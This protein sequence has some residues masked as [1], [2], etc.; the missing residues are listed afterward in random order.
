M[1]PLEI[2]GGVECTVNRVHDAF[3]DQLIANGHHDRIEDL[4]RFAALGLKRL[5]YPVLWERTAPESPDRLQFDWSDARMERM[6]AL[7]VDPI[8]GLLHH[9]SGPRYTSLMDR[10]FPQLFAQYA[11]AVAERYP[12]ANAYTPINEPLTTARF[13]GLY[14]HWFPHRRDD[15]SFARALVNQCRGTVL[16]MQAVRRV[17]SEALLVQTDDLGRTR[18]SPDLAY[19][20][21]FDNERRWLAWDLLCGTVDRHHPMWRYLISNGISNS[22]L[23]WFVDHPCPPDIIGVNYY[24]T[25]DRYLHED[26]HAFPRHTWGGNGLHQY[27]DVEAVRVMDE[28]EFGIGQVLWDCWERYRRTIAITE[29]HLG[30]HRD[31]Q[32]RWLYEIWNTANEVR[33]QGIDL[34]ALTVWALLGSFDWDSL[35]TNMRGHY[36]P[37]VFDLRG[38]GLRPTALAH[39]VQDLAT[40]QTPRNQQ[41]LR[42]RPWWRRPMRVFESLRQ[43]PS[44]EPQ[45]NASAATRSDGH[46]PQNPLLVTGATGLLGRAFARICDSR[47]LYT[48]LCSRTDLDICDVDQI[49]RLLDELR[50]WA[51]VNAAG[52]VRIGDA[53]RES[54]RCYELNVRGA[55]LLAAACERRGIRFVTFSSDLVFDGKSSS[56]YVETQNVRPLNVFGRSKAEAERAVIAVNPEALV[57]RTSACFGPWDEHNFVTTALRT[58]A[59][60]RPYRAMRDVIV[61]PTYVPDLVHASLDLLIDGVHGLW[62]LANVGRLSWADFAREAAQLARVRTDLL[63]AD[64]WRSFSGMPELPAFSALGSERGY[65]MPALDDALARYIAARPIAA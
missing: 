31:E 46:H 28:A 14:G 34:R 23:Q 51:V 63:A 27:A 29:V 44:R 37:G 45:S 26:L 52:Y 43:I 24:V 48:R 53:E 6:R 10:N 13:S 35:L 1:H 61:S 50:P 49:D 59:A 41:I 65:L 32:L 19:Q 55:E 18:S 25:S 30:C 3:H 42:E 5:R 8:V 40:G 4:D 47:G 38:A 60:G 11:Q 62:H 21:R 16:S 56:P 17:N 2:W 7:G 54:E 57:I 22:E 33:G 64:S 12:W 15:A 58:L 9:G 36:E 39:L 20:A